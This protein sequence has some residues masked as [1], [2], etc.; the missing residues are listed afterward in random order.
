MRERYLIQDKHRDVVF[1]ILDRK[2]KLFIN[3][4]QT[5]REEKM[6]NMI[7]HII[8]IQHVQ[9]DIEI[10]N[11]I[12]TP[13]K[14]LLGN[15]KTKEIHNRSAKKFKFE[16]DMI[17][18]MKFLKNSLITQN[19]E[20]YT[21]TKPILTKKEEVRNKKLTCGLWTSKDFPLKLSQLMTLIKV[22]GKHN[23][24]F[25]KLKDYL[26]NTTLKEVLS[27]HGF[28]V[29]IQIPM[30]YTVYAVVTFA[31][32]KKLNPEVDEYMKTFEIPEEY[33]LLNENKAFQY[34]GK[35]KEEIFSVLNV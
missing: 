9:T 13:S 35:S 3:P 2:N 34:I 24:N 26:S 1:A 33:E 29:R 17:T 19:Y 31:V 10:K 5:P 8:G 15:Q 11:M 4:L 16:S 14:N 25:K 18:K 32:F 21:K 6:E 27:S 23:N 22:L 12:W 7:R 30:G 20:E 28:P